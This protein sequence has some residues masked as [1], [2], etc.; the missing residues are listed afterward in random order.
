MNLKIFFS[1]LASTPIEFL[2]TNMLASDYEFCETDLKEEC[3]AS[4]EKSIGQYLFKAELPDDYELTNISEDYMQ[5][6]YKI[7]YFKRKVY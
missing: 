2:S 5:K 3:F 1:F 7:G 6:I 4:N